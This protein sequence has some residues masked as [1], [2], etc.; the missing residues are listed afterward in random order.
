MMSWICQNMLLSL[1]IKPVLL[2]SVACE[3]TRS[4]FDQHLPMRIDSTPCGIRKVNYIGFL[5]D[6][7]EWNVLSFL[8][9][10]NFCGCSKVVLKTQNQYILDI[11]ISR[12]VNKDSQIWQLNPTDTHRIWTILDILGSSINRFASSGVSCKFRLVMKCESSKDFVKR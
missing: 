8:L 3:L 10:P 9:F 1:Q 12:N 7:Q 2:F 6:Y 5:K 11:Q 4:C